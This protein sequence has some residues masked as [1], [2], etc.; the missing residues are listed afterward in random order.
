MNAPPAEWLPPLMAA[1]ATV[2]WLALCWQ[3]WRQHRARG[4]AEPSTLQRLCVSYA[5]QGGE[6]KHIA[7]RTVAWLCAAGVDASL[8]ALERLNAKALP[9]TLLIVASTHGDG[10]APDHAASVLTHWRALASHEAPSHHAVLALGDNHYSHFCAFGHQLDAQLTALGSRALWPLLAVNRLDNLLIQKWFQHLKTHFSLSNASIPTAEQASATRWR[11]VARTR[12]TPDETDTPLYWLALRPVMPA[13]PLQWRAG[14]TV[15]LR[16]AD[17]SADEPARLYS[18]ASLPE[19]GHLALVVRQHTRGRVSRWLCEQAA[20]GAEITLHERANSTFQVSA[21]TRA[22]L[23]LIGNGSGMGCL[24]ALL[25][26]QA[27]RHQHG[28]WLL[29]GERYPFDNSIENDF[30]AWHDSGHLVRL[31][32]V[33]SR[34]QPERRYVQ[35]AL[36]EQA[37]RVKQWMANGGAIRVCG[38]QAMGCA[39]DA[40]LREILGV[41]CMQSLASAGRYRRDL[42]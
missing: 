32:Y 41:D 28:H 15:A 18:I 23:L 6:A 25:Y 16:L 24:R 2:G 10:E 39:V 8:C 33:Y 7:E 36:R 27:Q 20:L 34:A 22:P 13:M 40:A 42:F 14:D 26:E 35:H 4:V 12:L 19:E 38:G 31:E 37:A 9:D 1:G 17:F 29:L 3:A 21:E 30:R 5:S 11:L